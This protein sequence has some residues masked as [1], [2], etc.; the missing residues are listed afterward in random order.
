VVEIIDETNRF[1]Q[2]ETLYRTLDA[3]MEELGLKDREL[4]VVL[5]GDA[6]IRTMNHADRGIDQPTDVLSYPTHE[7]DDEGVPIVSHLGDIVISVDSAT[8]QAAARGY[9]TMSEVLVLAA[10]GLTHLRGFDHPTEEAWQIFIKA[11]TRILQ[12]ARRS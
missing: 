4:T 5:C 12:L 7:P 1:P 3:F 6:E 2:V 11:Q 10:H 9:D 8:R